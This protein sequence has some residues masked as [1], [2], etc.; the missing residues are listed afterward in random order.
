MCAIIDITLL[1]VWHD[2]ATKLQ[3]AGCTFFKN[4]LLHSFGKT[5]CFLPYKRAKI[6]TKCHVSLRE[7]KKYPNSNNIEYFI[8]TLKK[9]IVY[10][11]IIY[12]LIV[13]LTV[14][15]KSYY[16][17]PICM[18]FIWGG[19]GRILMVLIMICIYN[20][21]YNII[22]YTGNNV[23]KLKSLNKYYWMKIKKKIIKIDKFGA[24]NN[25]FFLTP[26]TTGRASYIIRL[27][28]SPR[29]ISNV[30]VTSCALIIRH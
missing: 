4:I 11:T 7:V 19:M 5:L 23:F 25:C 13:V 20:L 30:I 16:I 9:T 12:S 18:W 10:I 28:T 21:Y 8:Y 3:C 14:A 22:T 17:H 26:S 29:G 6:L 15:T 24:V 2:V 1:F 27:C